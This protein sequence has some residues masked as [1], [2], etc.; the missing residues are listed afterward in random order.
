[1]FVSARAMIWWQSVAKNA[2]VRMVDVHYCR[3]TFASSRISRSRCNGD[4]DAF[5]VLVARRAS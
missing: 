1:M 4:A 5:S 2:L 3:E